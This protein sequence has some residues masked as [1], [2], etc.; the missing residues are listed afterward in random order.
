MNH[1][2]FVNFTPLFADSL[3]EYKKKDE[4]SDC[5]YKKKDEDSDCEYWH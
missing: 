4:D 5:E 3:H 2:C 1:Y